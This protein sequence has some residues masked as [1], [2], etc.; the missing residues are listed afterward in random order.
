MLGDSSINL[1]FEGFEPEYE[2]AHLISDSV[3]RLRLSAP[4]DS[5]MSVVIRKSKGLIQ[6]SCRIASRAGIFVAETVSDS[7]LRAIHK[8]E[9]KIE[10]QLDE[11]KRRRF[12]QSP[13][14]ALTAS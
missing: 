8:I 9:N 6:A 10:T 12:S 14:A 5:V 7:P 1:H 11:W 2:L 13:I 3:E 4:S